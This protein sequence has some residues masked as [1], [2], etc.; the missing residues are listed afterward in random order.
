M[1]KKSL[2]DSIEIKTP[3][4]A[5]WNEMKGT[6]KVRF[7]E[8]CALEVNN[9]STLTRKQA[10]KLIR[11]SNGR[12]C[13]RFVKNPVD[14]TPVFAEKL[15]RITRRA[16]IAAGVLSASLS[17]SAIAYAQNEPVSDKTN[18]DAAQTEVIKEKTPDPTR[19]AT[20]SG[21]VTDPSGAL[22]PGAFVKIINAGTGESFAT[23]TDEY[24]AYRFEN[25]QEGNYKLSASGGAGFAETMIDAVA[26][27][28][29]GE[30]VQAVSLKIAETTAVVN[31]AGEETLQY[32]SVT[33]GVI[34]LIE[35]RSGLHQAVFEE[36][37][38]K[39]SYFIS[40]GG[41]VNQKD[42]NFSRITPLFLA[43]ENGNAEI[44]ETLLNFRAKINVRDDNRQTP[45]MR[46]D[47]DASVDLVN[48]LIRYGAKVNLFDKDKNTALILA[49]R[50]AKP[51]VL[52]VLINHGANLNAQNS[53]GRT[54][55]ME[56]A[57]AD[58]LEN[59]RAL[60][61]AGANINLKDNDGETALDLT[62]E[63]EIGK[64][65]AAYGAIVKNDSN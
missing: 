20:L 44:A 37:L 15:Y 35:Y 29:G 36:D 16:G 25:L 26:V 42:K 55:L 28:A 6:D 1:S 27:Y 39:V 21:T 56:A 4:S 17:L 7:C 61:E 58:N 14:N 2:I 52:R 3:C 60:V 13:A 51:E 23:K 47:E 9:I 59:V 33:T 18:A 49:A 48:V 57:D 12:L 10:T 19:G 64:L 46:L 22:L 41:N 50:S 45:L 43:V 31:V 24:G 34:L 8:H 54:A 62:T 32:E 40:K 53:E 65:L 63:E 38:E 5:D 11:Q 30:T